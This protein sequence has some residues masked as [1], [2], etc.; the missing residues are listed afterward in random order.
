M[1]EYYTN[2]NNFWKDDL[3]NHNYAREVPFVAKNFDH[4]NRKY[5]NKDYL[6][7]SFNEE[8]PN[9]DRFK[10]ALDVTHGAVSWTCILPDVILPTHK[11]TFYTLR[12]EHNVSIEQCFRYLIFLEDA[13]FGQSVGFTKENITY[14]KA[15]DVWK[16]DSTELHYGVNASN[17]PFHTCQVSTFLV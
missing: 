17:I 6:L 8:L 4:L 7:Q 14:F 1:I 2:I 11:D 9:A 10:G 15:G 16:F 13:V 12:Q 3:A 5:Y